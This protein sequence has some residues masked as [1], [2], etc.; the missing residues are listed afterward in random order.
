VH[1]LP[2]PDAPAANT[3]L[4][5]HKGAKVATH[6]SNARQEGIFWLL[7]D[8]GLYPYVKEQYVGSAAFRQ[9]VDEL[10]VPEG[11][12]LINSV[13]V[14]ALHKSIGGLIRSVATRREAAG[15]RKAAGA[16]F[17]ALYNELEPQELTHL[18]TDQLLA[19]TIAPT[20]ADFQDQL[21]K[22]PSTTTWQLLGT[23]V[24]E[25][26]RPG[27]TPRLDK[28]EKAHYGYEMQT[29]AMAKKVKLLIDDVVR[30]VKALTP[31]DVRFLEA[32]ETQ[33]YW[34]V[35]ERDSVGREIIALV[36]A[37]LGDAQVIGQ[38]YDLLDPV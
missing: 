36:L 20:A 32:R 17:V 29:Q 13:R 30:K 16:E 5:E 26:Y 9:K 37:G 15:K 38:L 7:A 25:D 1:N 27:T 14:E 23:T 28:L 12:N 11:G 24:H 8:A 10:K 2:S 34:V 35:F 6:F 31:D 4:V 33:Q 21:T 19:S 18:A 3:R 22:V